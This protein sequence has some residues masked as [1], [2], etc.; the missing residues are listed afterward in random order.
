VPSRLFFKASELTSDPAAVLGLFLGLAWIFFS[1]R[2]YVKT[3]LSK[4]WGVDDGLL[5]I[6]IVSSAAMGGWHSCSRL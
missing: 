3:F 2:I 4:S 6:S 5:A 1:L